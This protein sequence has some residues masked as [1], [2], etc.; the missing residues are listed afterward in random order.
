M[1]PIPVEEWTGKDFKGSAIER[2]DWKRM[3]R[4][5][6]MFTV[7]DIMEAFEA[8]G[9]L[10]V[11]IAAFFGGLGGGVYSRPPT[12]NDVAKELSQERFGKSINY[13]DIPTTGAG[14]I[15]R[16][17][18]RRELERRL[19]PKERKELDKEEVKTEE[20]AEERKE[21]RRRKF[22]DIRR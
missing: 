19:N 12:L 21:R 1:L 9:L 18:I 7:D 17:R 11:P 15:F 6:L 4:E 13:D 22:Q 14:K 8:E 10:Q 5:T 20:R 3:L 16:K 2:G